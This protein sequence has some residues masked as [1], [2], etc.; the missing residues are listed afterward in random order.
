MKKVLFVASECVPFIKT[1]GLADVCGALPKEFD[2][3]YWDVRVVIPNYSCIKEQF[4]NQ[5]T[6]VDNFY[7]QAGPATGSK[8]VGIMTM[9]YEGI[10]YYF[11]DNQEY[12]D[13]TVPYGDLKWDIERFSYF[14]KAVLSMLPVIDFKP[15]I[16]HCHDWQAAM[17]PVFLKEMF[18]N[19]AVGG[20]RTVFTI[21]NLRFQGIYN[22]DTIK[23][24][25]NL[26]DYVF[27]DAVTDTQEE[28]KT[29]ILVEVDI[30]TE[31]NRYDAGTKRF[32]WDYPT[33]TIDILSH[34]KDMVMNELGISKVRTDYLSELIDELLN[35]YSGL[36]F[37]RLQ[38]LSNIS[39][40][41]NDTYRYREIKF[42][43]VDL[44]DSMCEE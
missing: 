17:V 37:A 2:K 29:Y 9:E 33:I 31:R 7:M 24:W 34:Q 19:T 43:A 14:D 13:V 3:K 1:G 12:F 23:Y 11:I 5:M 10:T 16:I 28:V 25:S 22:I 42:T 36:G 44:N 41:L 39:Y 15:D 21:H 18:A 32:Y 4:K 38:R 26:P 40:S 30:M 35:G 20:A 6:Y 27:E 8:Y